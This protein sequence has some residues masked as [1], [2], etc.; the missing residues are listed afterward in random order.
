[1]ER[2]YVNINTRA[3]HTYRSSSKP[4]LRQYFAPALNYLIFLFS[5]KSSEHR[6]DNVFFSQ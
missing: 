5:S 1:M 3:R 2:Q 6:K 4:L